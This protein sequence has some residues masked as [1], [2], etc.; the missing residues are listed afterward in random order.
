MYFGLSPCNNT[1]HD[2]YIVACTR[3]ASDF[4]LIKTLNEP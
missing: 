3:A 2:R 4:E 1:T